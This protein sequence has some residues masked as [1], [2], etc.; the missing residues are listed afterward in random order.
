IVLALV[1]II[2]LWAHV[3]LYLWMKFKMDEGVITRC[4]KDASVDM[5]SD[6]IA[7]QVE[8]SVERVEKV[9]LRSKE[10]QVGEGHEKIISLSVTG[11]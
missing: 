3:W 7:K 1:I 2:S 8:M 9:C 11:I 10:I 6:S 4:L 5:Q